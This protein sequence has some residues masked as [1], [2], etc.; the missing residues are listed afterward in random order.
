LTEAQK[1][2]LGPVV[3]GRGA[4]GRK[5]VGVREELEE[6][7]E[8]GPLG[9]VWRDFVETHRVWLFSAAVHAVG[10]VILALI[11][12][13]FND[14]QISLVS[15]AEMSEEELDFEN[16]EEVEF[17]HPEFGEIPPDIVDRLEPEPLEPLVD[18]LPAA[19]GIDA[20]SVALLTSSSLEKAVMT[21]PLAELGSG[22]GLEDQWGTG[23][24]KQGT[25]RGLAG[26]GRG[27]GGRGGRRANA[28]KL[29]ATKESESAVSLALKW[30][31]EHQ[32]PD[33]SWSFDH[34]KP[35][36]CR[37]QCRN[38]GELDNARIAATALGLLP[39]LGAGQ[40]HQVGQYRK[41]VAAGLNYLISRMDVGPNGGSLH[42][43]EGR[44]YGHGLATIALCEAY[45]MNMTP[46]EAKQK[47]RAVYTGEGAPSPAEI[48]EAKLTSGEQAVVD[49]LAER[50]G[51]AAQLALNYVMF[52]QDPAGG[53]WRYGPRQPGDT[54]VVG[55]QLMALMSGRL[56]YLRV[57]PRSLAKAS[58][59]L[60]HVAMDDYGSDYGYTGPERGSKATR[61]I[62]LLARMYLGWS[63]DHPGLTQ[64]VE[65]LS[66]WGP[67]RG[68]MYYDYYATQVMHH[69]GGEH[70]ERWNNVMRDS[71]V[72]SQAQAGHERGSWYFGGG[73]HGSSQGGRLYCT[74]LAAMTLE[75]Y[76]RHMPLYGR[77]IFDQVRQDAGG[78]EEDP[79]P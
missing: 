50:L 60:D 70:W 17:E 59:F 52:A 1:Q 28:E 13:P 74:A 54:S 11:M 73:D 66:A 58:G 18:N 23:K 69:Y 64:G 33:G 46:A 4:P 26:S 8:Q 9:L 14:D 65:G 71:L 45:A 44:M 37:G 15:S 61:A 36:L 27:M 55:W 75:V 67:S 48:K 41:T 40:T 57:D 12:L 34:T 32:Y 29:G 43:P 5:P 76:Y 79:D 19:E 38:P 56:S 39:F 77:D 63:R 53:G 22:T 31:S 49:R 6:L 10:F 20:A 35:Y 21:D 16:L 72:A 68:A 2:K 78:K 3:R 62:G 51:P 47:R 7:E 25:G 30:L 42:E 24:G